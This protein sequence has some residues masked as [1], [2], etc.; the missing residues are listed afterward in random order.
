MCCC[1]WFQSR[2]REGG[3]EREREVRNGVLEKCSAFD[4]LRVA[5]AVRHVRVH[6]RLR[7]SGMGGITIALVEAGIA[8]LRSVG[9]LMSQYT[10][11]LIADS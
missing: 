11:A 7:H 3:R 8:V 10:V 1:N 5:V 2:K 6:V 4:N 9:S